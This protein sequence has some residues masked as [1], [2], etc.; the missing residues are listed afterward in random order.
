MLLTL[1]FLYLSHQ[2]IL[3]FILLLCAIIWFFHGDRP[4]FHR[5]ICHFSLIFPV[6][7]A[8]FQL[9]D[10]QTFIFW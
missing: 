1:Q 7:Q 6:L 10:Y 2:L 4:V 8:I 3:L 5:L 9:I